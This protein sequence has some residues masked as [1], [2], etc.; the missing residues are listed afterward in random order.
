MHKDDVII[1]L[2]TEAHRRLVDEALP[3]VAAEC[4]AEISKALDDFLGR[5]IQYEYGDAI[6]FRESMDWEVDKNLRWG[7]A[8]AMVRL[9]NA[10]EAIHILVI[11]DEREILFEIGQSVPGVLPDLRVKRVVEINDS[12]FFGDQPWD[13]IVNPKNGWTR[14]HEAAFY[15]T[16]PPSFNRWEIEDF[17]G[18]SVA[19]VAAMQGTLPGCFKDWHLRNLNGDTVAHLA[20][21]CGHLPADFTQWS[22]RDGSGNTVAH[23]AARDGKLPHD[24]DQW[25]LINTHEACFGNTV[26]HEAAKAGTL[27]DGFTQWELSNCNGYSVAHAVLMQGDSL[28]DS[29]S[30]WDI[31]DKFGWSVAHEAISRGQQL[32][33]D[34]DHWDIADNDGWTVAHVAAKL[35]L[36][37]DNF[38]QWELSNDR[39]ITVQDVANEQA[40]RNKPAHKPGM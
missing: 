23:L 12:H 37:P 17:A 14:A 39:G 34:F 8:D 5:S 1:A 24:F 19:H 6:L 16:L 18:D 38:D 11:R 25:G 15:G 35:G 4:S 31:K 40:G 7:I 33:R 27:P 36:L 9:K 26:A 29:F 21:S 3:A 28:P 2:S 22:L 10:D 30:K 32:P 13:E 20:V